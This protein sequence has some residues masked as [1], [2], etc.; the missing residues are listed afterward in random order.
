MGGGWKTLILILKITFR[1]DTGFWAKRVQAPRQ[2]G[3]RFTSAYN[4]SDS[5]ADC[6][7]GNGCRP[8]FSESLCRP[9]A[10]VNW[11][12]FLRITT[13]GLREMLQEMAIG[14]LVPPREQAER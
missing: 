5:L 1:Y 7:A 4:A 3:T 8:E 6:A 2:Q 9:A 14:R 10:R 13:M 12:L 11:N